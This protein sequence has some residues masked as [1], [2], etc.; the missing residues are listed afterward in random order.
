MWCFIQSRCGVVSAALGVIRWVAG[1]MVLDAW[2]LVLGAWCLVL[3]VVM[4][5]RVVDLRRIWHVSS[6]LTI[7]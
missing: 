6:W 5:V 7:C 2:C 4:S 1:C 3:G